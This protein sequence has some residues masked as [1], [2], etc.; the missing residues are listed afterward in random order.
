MSTPENTPIEVVV[1][2]RERPSG[3]VEDI[4]ALWRPVA[5]GTLTVG[6]VV[7]GT[8]VRVERK[9]VH[10]FVDSLRDNRLF[11]QLYALRGECARP[12]LIVEGSDALPAAG[13]SAEALRGILLSV[14]VGYGVPMLRTQGTAETA[15]FVARIARREQRRLGRVRPNPKS[16]PLAVLAAIPG[17]GEARARCLLEHH[18]S[19]SAVLAADPQALA[20][21][22]GVGPRTAQQIHD[23][24]SAR[25]D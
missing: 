23:I 1:D 8:R 25:G 2:H 4:Q 24:G 13:V 16:G 18:G 5:V 9:T 15:L 20:Q 21:V 10:D 11:R 7:I 14:T 17:V 12:L 6:D 19:L 22:P 3:L